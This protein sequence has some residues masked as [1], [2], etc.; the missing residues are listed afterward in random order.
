MNLG[1][2][3]QLLFDLKPAVGDLTQHHNGLAGLAEMNEFY[4]S[5]ETRA[6]GQQWE[7]SNQQNTNNGRQ[8]KFKFPMKPTAL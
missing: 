7:N 3:G 2:I 5:A 4:R 6:Q 1:P 8:N